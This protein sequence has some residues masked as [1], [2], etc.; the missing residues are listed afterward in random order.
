M[1]IL[2]VDDDKL[3]ADQLKTNLKKKFQLVNA[4]YTF[5]TAIE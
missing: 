2:I 3:F 1:R 4:V 5:E